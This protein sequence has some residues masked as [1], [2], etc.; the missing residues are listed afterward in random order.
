LEYKILKKPFIFQQGKLKG[1]FSSLTGGMQEITELVKDQE[2]HHQ[3]LLKLADQ[4]TENIY[5][6][7]ELKAYSAYKRLAQGLL[8]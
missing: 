3:Y 7:K 4:L 8:T 6:L 2:R 1:I 5:T